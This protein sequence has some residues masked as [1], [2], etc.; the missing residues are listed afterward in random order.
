MFVDFRKRGSREGGEGGREREKNRERRRERL[1]INVREKHPLVAPFT[2][3]P[4][5]EPS[6]FR[7]TGQGSNQ[8][9]HPARAK[10]Y[11]LL[12]SFEIFIFYTLCDDEYFHT[13]TLSKF[14]FL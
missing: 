14:I 9:S 8:L 5:I 4:V 1:I 7:C 10:L 12:M 2:A 11:L 13:F 3:Q 6:G